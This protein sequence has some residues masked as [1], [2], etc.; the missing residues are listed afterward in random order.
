MS[1]TKIITELCKTQCDN[2]D[3]TCP[4]DIDITKAFLKFGDE[5]YKEG[6]IHASLNIRADIHP[7]AMDGKRP[8]LKQAEEDYQ[9]FIQHAEP[10]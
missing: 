9:D 3:C 8:T 5:V 7:D 4:T 2:S 10:E 6:F 1:I